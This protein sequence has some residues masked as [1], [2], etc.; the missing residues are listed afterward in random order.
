MQNK[1]Y[2]SMGQT[3]KPSS[4]SNVSAEPQTGLE[5]V[6]SRADAILNF[7]SHQGQRLSNIAIKLDGACPENGADVPRAQPAGLVAQINM[8]LDDI[9]TNL[10][11]TDEVVSRINHAV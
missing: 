10:Q 9:M 7:V 2:A 4:A 5:S 1:T 8:L 6:L 3:L 11:A